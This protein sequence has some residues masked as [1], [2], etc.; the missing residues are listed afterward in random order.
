MKIVSGI[1]DARTILMSE[2]GIVENSSSYT[3]SVE[4]II[5]YVRNDGD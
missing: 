1:E 5:Q 4:G 3:K 2:R